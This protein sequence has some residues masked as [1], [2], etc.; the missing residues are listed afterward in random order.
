MSKEEIRCRFCNN[1]P[2]RKTGFLQTIK[3]AKI[4]GSVSDGTN[5]YGAGIEVELEKTQKEEYYKCQAC[6]HEYVDISN[7]DINIIL[8]NLR[9]KPSVFGIFEAY[10]DSLIDII[11]LFRQHRTGIVRAR[12]SLKTLI[13]D[14]IQKKRIMIPVNFNNIRTFAVLERHLQETN[15]IPIYV[16]ISLGPPI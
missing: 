9:I 16:V 12:R 15:K 11:S 8:Q 4:D 14:T 3:K 1:I 5:D 13:S 6:D 10:Y 2:I 7:Y